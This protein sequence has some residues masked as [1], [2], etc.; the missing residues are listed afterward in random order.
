MTLFTVEV[1]ATTDS[2]FKLCSLSAVFET[3][4]REV[5][6]RGHFHTGSVSW[7][8]KSTMWILSKKYFLWSLKMRAQEFEPQVTGIT[9]ESNKE[10]KEDWNSL[11]RIEEH[12]QP[13]NGKGS[14]DVSICSNFTV[15]S[16]IIHESPSRN[17][18]PASN[19][20]SLQVSLVIHN[21]GN[22]C[23][24]WLPI[25]FK[26]SSSLCSLLLSIVMPVT[27][28]SNSCALILKP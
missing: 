5:L 26:V 25:L 9:I 22:F 10:H 27:C 7:K 24:F 2:S 3:V 12:K 23:C 21:M 6:L 17:M 28:G 13:L 1:L 8:L 14:V 15:N 19:A 4:R 18:N 16:R 11:K 20:S